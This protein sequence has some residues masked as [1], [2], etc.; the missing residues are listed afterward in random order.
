MINCKSI[1]NGNRID[2]SCTNKSNT[3][4]HLKLEIFDIDSDIKIVDYDF[5]ILDNINVWSILRHD[6]FESNVQNG[7]KIIITNK[8]DNKIEGVD[9]LLLHP[10]IKTKFIDSDN[11]LSTPMASELNHNLLSAYEQFEN[12]SLDLKNA[13][14]ILDLGSSI[15]VFTAYAL[16]Q[17]PNIKSICVEMNPNFHKVCSDT[18]KD[19][20]N[21]IPINAAIY[22]ESN[23]KILFKSMKEDMEDL[24]NNIVDDL[25]S[26]QIYSMKVD[27]ISI[28]D[29]IKTYNINRISLMKVDIEGYEY[30]LFDNISDETLNKIDKIFLEF[31]KAKD[32]QLKL[33]IIN[34]LMKKGFKMRSY[35]G[36]ID[37]YNTYMYSLLFLK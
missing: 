34:K 29:I 23:K 6:P 7:F 18:F 31:H 8:D 21:I 35:D 15:G 1:I 10:Y 28:E 30:E 27:A 25:F 2:V 9:V 24:G 14:M 3:F 16:E 22:K 13:K 37:C 4:K 36:D 11:L 33:D 20:P 19:N 17:N 32:N 5:D 12:D 26:D